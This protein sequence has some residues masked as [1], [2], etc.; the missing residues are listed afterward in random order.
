MVREGDWRVI[1]GM[2]CEALGGFGRL[3]S[4]ATVALK[5]QAQEVSVTFNGLDGGPGLGYVT[6]E[7]PWHRARDVGFEF[8]EFERPGLLGTRV[9]FSRVQLAALSQVA[10]SEAD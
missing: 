3:G 9:E 1:H 6:G 2:P 10:I 8:A 5:A 7:R 4:S